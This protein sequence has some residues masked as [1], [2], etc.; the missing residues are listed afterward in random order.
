MGLKSAYK[1]SNG[2]TYPSVFKSIVCTRLDTVVLKVCGR[3][4]GC[5]G[6]GVGALN[7]EHRGCGFE[8]RWFKSSSVS[9]RQKSQSTSASFNSAT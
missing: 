9:S 4:V 6:V 3:H 1:A 5:G 2:F 8:S 7:S